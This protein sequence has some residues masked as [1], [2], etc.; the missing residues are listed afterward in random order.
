MKEKNNIFEIDDFDEMTKTKDYENLLIFFTDFEKFTLH[1]Y[2]KV[3]SDISLH[4]DNSDKMIKMIDSF[5][6]QKCNKELNT[7]LS[8]VLKTY[9]KE[10]EGLKEE[11]RQQMMLMVLYLFFNNNISAKF[12]EED[13]N[14]TQEWI[15]FCNMLNDK[16]YDEIEKKMFQFFNLG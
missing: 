7:S 2:N 8:H 14:E 10:R 1:S 4:A 16:K 15:K 13:F 3:K 12:P 5:S 11:E 9:K 6:N